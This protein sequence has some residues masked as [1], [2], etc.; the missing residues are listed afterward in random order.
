MRNC[1]CNTRFDCTLLAIAA[2]I[3]VGITAAILSFTAIITVSTAFLWVAL[4]I[5]VVYLAILLVA[6]VGA[7]P[8]RNDCSCDSIPLILAGILLAILT[9]LILLAI[10]FPATSVLSA[11]IIGVL[12]GSLALIFTASACFIKCVTAFDCC[13]D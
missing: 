2:S 8:F 4:G 1:N 9:A 13:D 5:A 11:I 7:R 12:I 6:S 3:I 10:E